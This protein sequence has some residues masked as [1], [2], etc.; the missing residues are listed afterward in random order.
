[1]NR[2]IWLALGSFA[3][4]L[5]AGAWAQAPGGTADRRHLF[6]LIADGGGFRSE[7]FLFL[8]NAA[9]TAN[10]CALD[11]RGPGLGS[12][13]FGAHPAM[14]PANGGGASI[15]FDGANPNLVLRSGLDQA[16]TFGYATLDCE[17]PVAARM[18]LG[19]HDAGGPVS[20]TALESLRP[21]HSFQI[22]VL[23]RLGAQGLILVNESAGAAACSI[24]LVDDIGSSIGGAQVAVPGASA[25]LRRL[26][27]LIGIPPEMDFGSARIDCAQPVAAV[28]LP[29]N[30]AV[31][32]AL[33]AVALNEDAKGQLVQY[34]PLI[35]DGDGF[36]SRLLVTNL[37][38]GGN[39]C[40]LQLRGAGLESGRFGATG[41]ISASGRQAELA[42][43]AH[44][45][46]LSLPSLGGRGLVFGYARLACAGPA[47][48]S[49]LLT[50]GSPGNPA[51][52]AIVPGVNPA[53]RLQF[54]L[55]PGAN[56][57]FLVL[58]N[59]HEVEAGCQIELI[60]ANGGRRDA[61]LRRIPARATDL[62]PLADLAGAAESAAELD[63]APS[64]SAVSLPI[65]GAAFAAL[66]PTLARANTARPPPNPEPDPNPDPSANTAPFFGDVPPFTG[67]YPL[68][69]PIDPLQLPGSPAGNPPL[70]YTLEPAVPGLRFD[71]DSRRLTGAPTVES[72]YEMAYRVRDADGE[73]D[74]YFFDIRVAGPDTA[75]NFT[76]VA[77]PNRTFTLGRE[78]APL[79]LPV[80]REG[81]QPI[82]YSL[83]PRVPGLRFDAAKRQLIG[84]PWLPGEYELSYTATDYHGE[85]AEL[86]FTVLVEADIDP[87]L[88]LNPESCANGDFIDGTESSAAL[89]DD[90]RVMVGFANH[91][92]RAGLIKDDNVVRRW[93]LGAQRKLDD[94]EGV[95]V[96]GGRVVELLLADS[97]LRGGFP[98]GLGQLD[99]LNTLDLRGNYLSGRIPAELGELANLRQL[100]L[101]SNVLSG[102]I[103]PALGGLRELYWLWLANNGLS[104]EIPPELGQ[105]TNLVNLNLGANQLSGEIPES[106]ARLGNLTALIL[107]GN[108]LTGE[109]PPQLGQLAQ[110]ASLRLGGNQLSGPIPGAL[111]QLRRLRFLVVDGNQLS[112]PIPAEIGDLRQLVVFSASD[113]QLTGTIPPGLSDLQNLQSLWLENNRLSGPLHEGFARLPQLDTLI[114]TGNRL[115]GE[116]A[117]AFKE[118][119]DSGELYLEIDSNLLTGYPPLPQRERNPAY[120]PS[121]SANGNASHHS[122]AY[123]QG[124]LV[125]EWDWEGDRIAHQTPILG[126]WA[127]LAVRVDH[128]VEAPP[129]VAT[130][131]LGPDGAVLAEKLAEAAHPATAEMAPG[132]WRSEYLF[133]L[134]GEWFQAG[135]R[136]IHEIDPENEL[137]ETD[138]SDNIS[139]A[140]VLDG[141]QPPKFRV[142]FIPVQFT[143]DEP[144]ITD[145]DLDALMRGTS[146][147]LPIADDYEARIGEPLWMSS[148]NRNDAL[149]RILQRWNL[150]ARE[151]EFFH[152][153][154]D[155]L[156]RGTAF[157]D[158][159]AALSS[160]SPHGT[161][162][163]EFG[164]NFSLSHT[165]GCAADYPD[166][167]YPHP[168]GRLGPGRG[169]D[170]NWRRWV[171][172]GD[173]PDGSYASD[174]M[175]YCGWGH[176]VS[177]YNYRKLTQYW[178][179]QGVE[180]A[181]SAVTALPPGGGSAEDSANADGTRAPAGGD[182]LALSG[183]VRPG[184]QWSL[185][186]AQW[187]ARAPRRPADGGGHTLLLFD[188]AGARLHAE[189]LAV[190]RIKEDGGL[191]WAARPPPPL[192]AAR[193]IVIVDADG[194]EVLRAS[195]PDL[196]G[197]GAN[198]GAVAGSGG[199]P[200]PASGKAPVSS[201]LA[202]TVTAAVTA[203]G[204][205]D[206]DGCSNGEFIDDPGA[207]P[208]LVADCQILVSF[209]NSRIE[210]NQVFDDHPL[211][212]WATG[213]QRKLV[214]WAGVT[215]RDDRVRAINLFESRLRGPLPVEFARLDA[216]ESLD[217]AFNNLSGSIPAEY[218]N[219][220]ALRD[221]RLSANQLGGPLPPA[222][223]RLAN[224]ETFQVDGNRLSGPVPPWLAGLRRLR[225]LNLSI[226][227]F[228]GAIPVE[229]AQFPELTILD[230]AG[231]DLT[232]PIPPELGLLRKLILLDL[233]NNRLT[234][235][236]PK[237]L[238][239]LRELEWLVL[240]ENQLTGPIPAIFGEFP[241]IYSINLNRNRLTGT[242]PVELAGLE[243]LTRLNVQY[244]RL[245][246]PV[247][248]AYW[249]R[250]ARGGLDFS[251]NGNLVGA[252]AP[253][254]ISTPTAPPAFSANPADNGNASHHA[255]AHFQGPLVMEW[256]WAGSGDS[257]RIEHQ[258][259]IL[260]RWV[261]LAASV[262]HEVETPPP[263]ITRVLDENGA[264]LDE[265]LELAAPPS[266]V[267][268]GAGRWR[269]EY[270]FHLPGELHRAGNQVVHVIDPEN[271]LAET[272]ENDNVSPTVALDGEPVPKLRVTFIPVRLADKGAD[273][274][275]ENID[276]EALLGGMRGLMPIADEVEAR[277]GQPLQTDARNIGP[278]I[279][280]LLRLW[281]LQADPDEFYHGITDLSENGLGYISGQVA[282][283]PLSIFRVI[284]HEFGHN[285]S[286]AHTPGCGA[287]ATDDEYPWVDGALGPS[288]AWDPGLRQFATGESGRFVDVMSYCGFS[289]SISSYNYR[290]ASE[291]W[292][293]MWP[294]PG[295]A[296][297][298]GVSSALNVAADPGRAS[299]PPTVAGTNAAESRHAVAEAQAL[300]LA[301]AVDAAGGWRL[302]QAQRSP[303]PPRPPQERGDHILLLFDSAGVQLHAEPLTL[304]LPP[305]DADGALWAARVPLPPRA[306][307]EIAILDPHGHEVLRVPLPVLR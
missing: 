129:A 140:V 259:P 286:L 181:T 91:F 263:V 66:A 52:M 273:I 1:M 174:I 17:E 161:V 227:R 212:Q 170:P 12:G 98:A 276:P 218:G 211:R 81:N 136:I 155:T 305:E 145:A 195:L 302:I 225:W 35:A 63:C 28:A 131:V 244:N 101:S 297:G 139:K 301:G 198:P 77:P 50:I 168:N 248:W 159:R 147:M 274:W 46:Q 127:V 107:E 247:P 256:N 193:E 233:H 128:G 10:H 251:A 201:P 76:G 231:N 118:R 95:T 116:V 294:R 23:P 137:A 223:A 239:R 206:A 279:E 295:S 207:H 290:L 86:R 272:D 240:G 216:L 191:M 87:A 258:T 188:R 135:N 108:A 124:P 261:A 237:E 203:A 15:T 89:A 156:A 214:D 226:N 48:A 300:A 235:R 44:G 141:E 285:L 70:R 232:G 153:I 178:L 110:L 194:N 39:D 99:A 47:A 113:N 33:P 114:V 36:R 280:D 78:I 4:L 125:L 209:A 284:P 166:V 199:G 61:G 190:M 65:H 132:R 62:V 254:P 72:T 109:I 112:G 304:M 154:S 266:T 277:I 298:A 75:P 230:L 307:R 122:I 150:E 56:E 187:S 282:L 79:Q 97:D 142:T 119:T 8:T 158:A 13:I 93:G 271:L 58:N 105:L 49:S 241:D 287:V 183:V 192:R 164:H 5:S 24:E 189:P 115:R 260:G 106:L 204:T 242:V 169:W 171:E 217:L 40:S 205:I 255:V 303:K 267:A 289:L 278:A 60:D 138:E 68:G 182:S 103:P 26:D 38:D 42:F 30:G 257:N 152:G 215:V 85:T 288:R 252:F 80:A 177:S 268:V 104:G 143:S 222:L 133:H 7:L 19:W 265:S 149:Y 243:T 43:S 25:G 67:V 221:L 210:A 20:I 82:A 162:P 74:F 236:I 262:D 229:I 246:G 34:L 73:Q 130:R 22:P 45:E 64:A 224:L 197:A 172:Q 163:H 293:N 59:D 296:S 151:N 21:G 69:S 51:A 186:Q 31:F 54:P 275:W 57:Q 11:V 264:V 238:V 92:I 270:V 167:E 306:A 200:A 121:A 219:L 245:T 173:R 220:S 249:E 299:G 126:R 27:E 157:I 71:A 180:T 90:C 176:F 88:L 292:R 184:G 120:S 148:G 18:L 111:G 53:S 213:P 41:G 234:G 208:G 96:E 202:G 165:P 134:P 160:A 281:N 269:S 123:Y 84:A 144:W 283:S 179:A 9:G 94:W 6:P 55:V 102:G 16:L 146:A 250:V 100:Y 29:V 228:S 2:L 3:L 253:P 37:A 196:V 32:A 14:A 117:W 291:Y 185:E 175:S 83:K